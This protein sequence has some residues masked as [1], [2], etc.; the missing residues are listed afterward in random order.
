MSLRRSLLSLV[1]GGVALLGWLLPS[2]QEE[3][4]NQQVEQRRNSSI[5]SPF[6]DSMD[7]ACRQKWYS[8]VS[9]ED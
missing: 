3:C 2:S 6:A 4:H 5:A 1:N 7:G 8:S 9:G